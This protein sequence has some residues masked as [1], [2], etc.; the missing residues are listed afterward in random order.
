MGVRIGALRENDI[1]QGSCGWGL[2]QI[3][4]GSPAQLPGVVSA[5]RPIPEAR[6]VS[7]SCVDA[8]PPVTEAGI[9]IPETI[10]LYQ[11]D[12]WTP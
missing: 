7:H 11:K 10:S 4:M 9:A 3:P 12:V 8:Q 2:S 1:P 5:G 6:K